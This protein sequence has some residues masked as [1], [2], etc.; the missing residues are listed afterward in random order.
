MKNYPDWFASVGKVLV[1]KQDGSFVAI[2]QAEYEKLK[3][4]GRIDVEI[5][6]TMGG[7]VTDLTQ[8]PILVLREWYASI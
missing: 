4:E 8:R 3:R 2:D 6:K 7:K 1:K 5:P